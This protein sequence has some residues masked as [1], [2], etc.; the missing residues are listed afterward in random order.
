LVEF[1]FIFDAAR[2]VFG[3][4]AWRRGMVNPAVSLAGTVVAVTGAVGSHRLGNSSRLPGVV[5]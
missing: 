2:A 3:A 1:A 4:G 5:V